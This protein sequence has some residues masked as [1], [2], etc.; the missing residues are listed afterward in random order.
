[1][2]E[3]SEKTK[4]LSI[5]LPKVTFEAIPIKDLVTDQ[6]YQRVLS[7]KHVKN[8]IANFD[9]YQL[10]PVRVS[11]REGINYVIDG[12]HTMETVAAASES[13]DT[14]V[15]CMVYDDLVYQREAEIFANQQ[16]YV[17]ALTPYEI[18]MANIEAGNEKQLLIKKIVENHNLKISPMSKAGSIGAVSALEYIY[19]H[20]GVEI[21]NRT[22]RLVIKV[23]EGSHLSLGSGI[24]KGTAVVLDAMGDEIKDELFVERLG[25]ISEREIIRTARE[26]RGGQMGYAEAILLCYNKKAHAGTALDMLY[27]RK[28]RRKKKAENGVT[29]DGRWTENTEG[30]NLETEE[31]GTADD[32]TGGAGETVSDS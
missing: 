10:R 32:G 15:W 4:D 19:D 2:I 26:R 8:I 23:W 20:Y 12:Q 27:R 21:L 5:F 24:L 7:E 16:K 17:K 6:E 28:G 18:F 22:L 1:M 31:Q 29:P 25:Y 13:R 11:R 3:H 30:S 9:P 14:K